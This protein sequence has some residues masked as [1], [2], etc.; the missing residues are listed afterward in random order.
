MTQI[1]RI[2]I[3]VPLVVGAVAFICTS[4]IHA[5]PLSAMVK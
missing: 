5:L 2:A 1:H 3:L 4:V